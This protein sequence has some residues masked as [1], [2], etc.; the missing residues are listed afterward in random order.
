MRTMFFMSA[1]HENSEHALSRDQISQA[2][3]TGSNPGPN[4]VSSVNP[5]FGGFAA[6]MIG[7]LTISS[8]GY[9]QGPSFDV[10][11]RSS[12]DIRQILVVSPGERGQACDV[13]YTRDYGASV[14]TPYYANSDV[15]FCVDKA[16]GLR[17][18]LRSANYECSGRGNQL[19]SRP[20]EQPQ[21][22][23]VSSPVSASVAA[24][25]APQVQT[26]SIAAP[27]AATPTA[28]ATPQET[29]AESG[30]S[31]REAFLRRLKT[32]APVV[33]D[34][35]RLAETSASI[36]KTVEA[37][38]APQSAASG[39]SVPAPAESLVESVAPAEPLKQAVKATIADNQVTT[40]QVTATADELVGPVLPEAGLPK[41]ANTEYAPAPES[42]FAHTQAAD[43]GPIALVVPDAQPSSARSKAVNG[44]ALE[45]PVYSGLVPT[46]AQNAKLV[47]A[48][49][50]VLA[51]S[52]VAAPEPSADLSPAT[53]S[54]ASASSTP[55]IITSVLSATTSDQPRSRPE[56]IK[57]ALAAQAAAWNEGDI[58]AFMEGY[59]RDADLRFV[60]GTEVSK[61]WTK[62][63][64]RYRDRYGNG[65]QLGQ[66]TFEDLDVQMVTEDVA[67]VVGRFALARTE[68]NSSGLYTLV[69]K[70]F[71][72][73][74]RIVH[75]HTVADAPAEENA[76]GD[77]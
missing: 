53:P 57:A 47:G 69:M 67:I 48:T 25:A 32:P 11:C 59:W 5:R 46:R 17:D 8:A 28:P 15:S 13:I 24:P 39:F 21:A 54:A 68:G 18:K 4:K 60:S 65:A 23:A 1:A 14:S 3:E 50:V 61:G 75:D 62:T 42:V 20:T 36:E 71:E 22:Q 6:I 49:P 56:I 66:L 76:D 34:S 31:S 64:K 73:A 41:V 7:A 27:T 55:S 16:V 70:R 77:E 10:S 37:A 19:A 26:V 44:A 72:G 38:T 12:D 45:R 74:W 40:N 33:H 2:Q 51:S 35:A 9:A 63:L 29:S 43:S 30:L 58:E 52:Q